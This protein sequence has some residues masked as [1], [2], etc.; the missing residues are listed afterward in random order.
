MASRLV[1]WLLI[2]VSLSLAVLIGG[3]WWVNRP[4]AGAATAK[5]QLIEVRPGATLASVASELERSGL[6]RDANQFRILA[7]LRGHETIKVGEY[8]I[9]PALRPTEIL[10]RLNSGI[11]VRHTLTIPEGF[12]VFEIASEVER[13]QLGKASDLVR[14]AFDKPFVESLLGP[15]IESLEGYLFP[16]TYHLTKFTGVPGILKLMVER[17]KD[18]FDQL[19]PHRHA[20][21]RH[22]LVTLA[23]IIEK[24]TGAPEERAVISSVFH[25]RL[26]LGMKL[27]TDPTVIYGVWRREGVWAGNIRRSHLTE[28]TPYNTYVIKGLPPGPIANPGKEALRSAGFPAATPFLFFVSRNDGTHVFSET[29][30]KHNSAVR[31][32]QLD[33]RAREGKSWRDLQRVRA[34]KPSVSE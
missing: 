30:A 22:Q 13:R 9:T 20:L 17:F 12:N 25:N 16:D 34:T 1:G 21:T 32:F 26:R 3:Q 15:G 29:Y 31:A 19:P 18:N 4:M 5:T 24:E 8:E 23:S 10:E 7:K 6:I 14:L 33:R 28:P 2:L 27:Q 11:S